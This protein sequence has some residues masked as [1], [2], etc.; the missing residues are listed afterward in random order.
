M[1]DLSGATAISAIGVGPST[2]QCIHLPALLYGSKI[3]VEVSEC[4]FH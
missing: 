4:P 2:L 3:T 1:L